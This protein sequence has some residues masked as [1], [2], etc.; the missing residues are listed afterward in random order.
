VNRTIQ[1]VPG[2]SREALQRLVDEQAALRRVA[3]L[4]A[5]GVRPAEIFAAVS[6][7]VGR[8]VGTDSATVIRYDDDG[9]GISYVGSASKV[10]AAFP[11]GVHWKF[12]EGMAS[13]DVYRTGRS[14][15]SGAHLITVDGPIGD[16]H[17]RMG[18]V[19]AVASPIIVQGRLWGAMAVHGQETLPP[20]TE[21]RVEKFT[22]LVATAIANAESREALERLAD[23]QAALRRVA[24]LVAA[25]GVRPDE[26]FAAVSDEVSRL[27]GTDT[28]TVLKYDDEGTGII[29]VGV[30]S[31]VSGAFP[32]G[33]HWLFQDGMAS[34]EVYRTGRSARTGEHLSTVPGTVGDIQRHLGIM[35]AVA[36]PI[37]VEGSLWGAM[38]VQSREP[39][40][41]DTDER[42]EK[43]TEL[44]ATAIANAEAREARARLADEQAA[45]RRVATLVAQGTSPAKVFSALCE[46]VNRLVE[47]QATTIVRLEPD[48][49]VA[50]VA[51]SGPVGA[52]VTLGSRFELDTLPVAGAV[53]RT[54]RSARKDFGDVPRPP[55]DAPD[56]SV[57]VAAPIVVDRRLWGCITVSW[58]GGEPPPDDTEERLAQFAELLDT[59]IANADSRDQLTASRAR[60]MTEGDEARRRVVRDLHDG[61]QQRLVH[62][63]VTLK[64]ARR[65]FQAQD[66]KG[67]LLVKE[68]LAHAERSNEE[69]RE[70]AHGILPSVLSHGGL[71][72]GVRAFAARLDMPVQVNVPADRFPADVEASVYFIVAEAL[73]N[74][75]KHAQAQLAE[76]KA[77]VDEDVLRVEIR[78]DG[79]GGADCDGHGLVGLGDRATTLGGRLEIDSPPGG[80]TLVVAAIPLPR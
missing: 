11:L 38:S 6:N 43:F 17:R 8:L 72:A 71:R 14:A 15:R 49:K 61:A 56:V 39:L 63:I 36:S 76:V 5:Q 54:G 70:L 33:A 40:P 34:A 78:D 20:D 24:M 41:P 32:L 4:V 64:L 21:E 55:P 66:G 35:S 13:F 68:A 29:F 18:I 7:E 44:V 79:V 62:T 52:D 60:V 47:A 28:A 57:R 59:A 12:Q 1:P 77:S 51:F 37:V 27:F 48:G 74:V 46:E 22:E 50:V 58:H 30:A 69:L 10:S 31:R 23:E 73:T 45:L 9:E 26:L 53:L 2:E 19:S 42:V 3:V 67:E 16:T 65:A 25:D 80:G 75:V